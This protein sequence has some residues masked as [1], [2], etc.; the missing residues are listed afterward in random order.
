MRSNQ[1]LRDPAGR[2]RA[3]GRP[4]GR[5]RR[6]DPRRALQ[7]GAA[8]AARATLA[9]A[10]TVTDTA[11]SG[12]R[13][14]APR[15]LRTAASCWSR[16]ACSPCDQGRTF[17]HAGRR[18]A[19]RQLPHRRRA[20]PR[21]PRRPAPDYY[22]ELPKL[23]E[24]PLARVSA[25]LRSG[26]GFRRAHRQPLRPGDAAS[27]R[28]RLSDARPLT[29][30]ELWAI[31][32][33][34]GRPRREPPPPRGADRA[35]PG[36]AAEGGRARRRPARP[37]ARTQSG[38]RSRHPCVDSRVAALPTAGPRPALPA[39]ARSGS[40]G[41]PRPP[42]AGGAPRGPGARRRGDGPTRGTTSTRRR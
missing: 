27:V 9:A 21:D 11:A 34:L 19:R 31:A 7:R 36:S 23:A 1:P 41:H 5:A 17:D 2:V 14:R 42:L 13:G 29:I 22:R 33:S 18:V 15:S 4:A 35:Q 37:P 38:G 3:R 32:I 20:A 8:R 30:G 6:A 40:S 24:G 16:T 12:T 25:R 26:L 28:A 10:Q 39:P